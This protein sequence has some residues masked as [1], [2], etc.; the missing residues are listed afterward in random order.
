MG[1]TTEK[2]K[3]KTSNKMKMNPEHFQFTLFL[4]KQFRLFTG[5]FP[6]LFW[7]RVVYPLSAMDV[8]KHHQRDR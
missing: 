6:L 3:E 5:E 2:E 8:F 4:C 1:K 7:C